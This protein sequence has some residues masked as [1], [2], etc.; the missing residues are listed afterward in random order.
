MDLTTFGQSNVLTVRPSRETVIYRLGPVHRGGPLAW[1][2]LAW[3]RASGGGNR[4]DD[5]RGPRAKFT[6][7][8]GAENVDA[9]YAELLD[10]FRPGHSW[11]AKVLAGIPTLAPGDLDNFDP[12]A[13]AKAIGPGRVSSDFFARRRIAAFSVLSPKPFLDVRSDATETAEA[14]SIDPDMAGQLRRISRPRVKPGDFMGNDRAITQAIAL[15]A[16]R[17]D[18]AG[19][20]YTSSH[21]L[22]HKWNC[23]AL[24]SGAEVIEIGPAQEI[25]V[26]DS[27]LTSIARR[28]NLA[29]G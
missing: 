2:D 6:T 8:Y 9:C 29:I 26:D 24:F 13:A 7:L 11:V 23:W 1:P 16:F 19:L 18:F 12:G 21:D 25:A 5:P 17:H 20:V 3:V 15:W 22:Q 28:F 10:Q 14:L 27:A 4:F